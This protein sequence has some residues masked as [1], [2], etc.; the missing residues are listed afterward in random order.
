MHTALNKLLAQTASKGEKPAPSKAGTAV[1][2]SKGVS[3]PSR[4]QLAVLKGLADEAELT[5]DRGAADTYHQ[6]RILAPAN[7]QVSF[8]ASRSMQSFSHQ[9]ISLTCCNN[10]LLLLVESH[11][12]CHSCL[13]YGACQPM[14]H[15]KAAGSTDHGCVRT[16][17]MV[18][19]WHLLL[20]HRQAGPSR[21]VPQRSNSH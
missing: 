11:F 1:S 7:A 5:G 6:E 19:V 3:S 9:L 20:T 21:A 15:R 2:R 8:H 4:H 13:P 17:G 12:A 14:M 18:R 16:V 10:D